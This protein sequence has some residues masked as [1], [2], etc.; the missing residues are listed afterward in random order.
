MATT[1]DQPIL[2]ISDELVGDVR[3]LRCVG[4]IDM[5]S[6]PGLRE[7]IAGHQVDGPPHLVLD[8]TGVTFIDS[9]GLGALIGAHKR[10]RV[11]Q[12]SLLMVPSDATRRV[13]TATALDR[14]F[15]LRPTL[16]AAL[17]TG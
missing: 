15:E 10:A 5:A 1:D 3:V 9:L 11:L 4:E 13:L 6:A 16:A 12:G 2:A 14:V 7:R 8:L 17:P